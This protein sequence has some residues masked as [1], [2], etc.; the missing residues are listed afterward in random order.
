MYFECILDVFWMYFGCILDVFWMY[1]GC[2][3]D[4]FWMYFGCIL[5]VGSETPHM[6]L[7]YGKNAS[8]TW[9]Y[10]EYKEVCR[11]SR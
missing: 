8:R 4:V 6:S 5:D 1:F 2:I 10:N 11:I 9:A 3:L 7:T